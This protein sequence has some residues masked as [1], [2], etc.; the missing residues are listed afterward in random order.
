[1]PR[2]LL[3]LGP[4]TL[5]GLCADKLCDL[6]SNVLLDE[7]IQSGFGVLCKVGLDAKFSGER[8]EWA[9]P[10]DERVVLRGG[11]RVVAGCSVTGCCAAAACVTLYVI[12]RRMERCQTGD[13]KRGEV[14]VA[15]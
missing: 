14:S 9:K 7:Y 10:S 2:T 1:M 12:G 3:S 4:S 8:D 6:S 13:G 15:C 5:H 11:N